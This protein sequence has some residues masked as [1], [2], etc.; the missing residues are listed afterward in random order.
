MPTAREHLTSAVVDNKLYVIGGRQADN[1]SPKV[2][3]DRVEMYNPLNDSWTVLEQMPTKR[4]GIASCSLHQL[5]V[6]FTY[7]E[8]KIHLRKKGQLEHWI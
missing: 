7:S 5:M 6:I 3:F 4:S 2:N 1:G 8:V